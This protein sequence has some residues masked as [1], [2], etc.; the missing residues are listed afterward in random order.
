MPHRANRSSAINCGSPAGRQPV[1]QFG[2]GPV[3]H[4]DGTTPDHVA[5]VIDPDTG[6]LRRQIGIVD[7][8]FE[9]YESVL[10]VLSRRW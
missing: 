6:A 2:L 8:Q 1:Q 4:N 3:E 5:M 7:L 9:L 10:V